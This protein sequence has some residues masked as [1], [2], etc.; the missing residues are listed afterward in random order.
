MIRKGTY[1]LIITLGADAD[2][3]VGSL[4]TLHFDAGT[5]CYVGSAMGGLDQRLSRHLSRT[6]TVRWHID[7]LTLA[8]DGISAYESFPDYV[9]ECRLADMAKDCGMIPVH[10]GFG[11]SDCRCSTHL[12]KT[13]DD[14]LLSLVDM[15]GLEPFVESH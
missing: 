9:P 5:Y 6:K 2:I 8:A 3:G 7:R 4:G 14:S 15:T 11:C 13:D 10:P 12:F 1:I